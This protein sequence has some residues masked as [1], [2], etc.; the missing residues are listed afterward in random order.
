MLDPLPA[1]ATTVLDWTWEQ[2]A[3]YYAELGE[4][5]LADATVDAWLADWS[6]VSE[7][8][9]EYG[10]RLQVALH[11]NT[12]EQAA[13][14]RYFCFL[15]TIARPAEEAEHMLKQRLL[16]SGLRPERM[17][18]PLRVMRAEAEL[19]RAENVAL[20]IEENKLGAQYDKIV[21]AQTVIWDGR[22]TPLPQLRAVFTGSNRARR[23]RAWWLARER[24]LAD[25]PQLDALW[26]EML[27]LRGRIAANAGHADYRSYIWQ[28]YH[29]FDY[30]PDDCARFHAAIESA[31][32]PAAT[33]VYE[34]RRRA[35]GAATLRP[36]DLVN[37]EWGPLSEKPGRRPLAPYRNT[38]ELLEKT[39]SVLKRVDTR[40]G[41]YFRRLI[42]EHLLDVENRAG[43]APGAYC[44]FFGVSRRPF[45]F[46]NA[47]G[48]HNDVQTL[49]HEAGH[50]F[51]AFEAGRLPY[52]QQL[53]APMEFNEVAS[54]AMELLAA[55]YLAAEDGGFYDAAGAA[56]ARVEHL[57]EMLLFWPYMAVVDAFQHWA[58]THPADAANS[59]RCDAE[60]QALWRRYIPGVD[61]SGL[62][63]ELVSGWQR[64]LHIFR[65]PFYYVE[66][67]LAQLGAAQVWRGALQ[68]Q[69]RAV[70]RY[71]QA[72]GLGGTASL[73][74]LYA[75]AGARFAFDTATLG[76][77]V[78][79]IERTIGELS[80]EARR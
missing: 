17:E 24:Q 62:E 48:Q 58:Y 15:D 3:P 2:F 80:E 79:L 53:G 43:K 72:L 49:L 12:A 27:A 65:S 76:E 50:A 36:W 28:A 10:V 5:P 59:S 47:V 30:T 31:V 32:V 68:N 7:L 54:M 18:V 61:W 69:P 42:D 38:A 77:A 25:R 66:Y 67:G 11:S 56:R 6:R 8:I 52:F 46:M 14:E 35:L 57:E 1:E 20:I 44:T 29:R 73:P 26:R 64:R 70:E 13:E 22:E 63:A 34:R 9:S 78:E 41:A 19:F 74:K 39:A 16:R 23:E 40:L 33:R 71:Q 75:T 21:G 37:G 60:W 55:P 4:R 45:V 51:H